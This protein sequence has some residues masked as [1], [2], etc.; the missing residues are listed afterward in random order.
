M[1]QFRQN[2]NRYMRVLVFFLSI[3]II[4]T[5]NWKGLLSNMW[6]LASALSLMA[7]MK[8][9]GRNLASTILTFGPTSLS[10]IIFANSAAVSSRTDGFCELQN[11]LSR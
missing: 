6:T 2:R 3:H 8:T 5:G 4:G 1:L 7:S 9:R 10:V 11:R